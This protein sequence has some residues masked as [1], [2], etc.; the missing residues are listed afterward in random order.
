MNLQERLQRLWCLKE[1]NEKALR[2]TLRHGAAYV[3][4]TIGCSS[5]TPLARVL[6]AFQRKVFSRLPAQATAGTEWLQV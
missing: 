6:A 3:T 5:C 1:Q 4:E 2:E